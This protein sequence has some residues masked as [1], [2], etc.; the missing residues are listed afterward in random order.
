VNQLIANL[1]SNAAKFG[2][3]DGAIGLE[4]VRREGAAVLTVSNAGFPIPDED[5]GR[6]FERFF[7]GDRSRSRKIGGAGLGLSL[8]REIARAHGGDLVL[9][10]SDAALT[11]F[12][13]TLPTAG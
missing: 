12:K 10:R 4:L 5:R 13:L 6:I 11:V 3:P 7:R 8:A 2:A 9:E 1:V